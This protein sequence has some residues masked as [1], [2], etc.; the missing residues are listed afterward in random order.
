MW[1]DAHIL[2]HDALCDDTQA[3]AIME[4]VNNR[5]DGDSMISSEKMTLI[6]KNG[7][8]RVRKLKSFSKDFDMTTRRI[9]FFI[10]PA[11]V[12]N[13]AFLTFDY[14]QAQKDD[15]Q[16]LYL[17]A[18]KK[19]RR[20]ASSDKS[21]SFMGSDFSYGDMTK[22]ELTKFDFKLIR[23]E[24]VD[25]KLCWLIE[26]KPR[27]QEVIDEYGYSKS[28]VLVRKDNHVILR[29]VFWLKKSKKVKYMQVKKLEQI[30]GIWTPMEIHMTTRNAS[31][32][33]HKTILH[34]VT[35]K[36]NQQIDQNLFT[37]RKM[38]MGI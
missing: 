37:T 27:S 32:V 33:E 21:S 16:W 11:D 10:E 19:V 1:S 20:I 17:P 29:S 26:C 3:R 24:V 8:Q 7:N 36:Y 30:D 38:E 2:P 23:E 25:E 9:L 35:V 28:I 13:T 12:Y 22:P 34:R 31:H 18:L 15:D 6:D 14:E 4:R 5:D